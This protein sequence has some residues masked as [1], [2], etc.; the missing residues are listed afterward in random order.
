M[1][2]YNSSHHGRQCRPHWLR[3]N[4][5]CFCKIPILP[6]SV[7]IWLVSPANRFSLTL[8]ISVCVQ[9]PPGHPS[10]G[11]CRTGEHKSSQ[12]R[13]FWWMLSLRPWEWCVSIFYDKLNKC[14]ILQKLRGPHTKI[15][16]VF[17]PHTPHFEKAS[18][19]VIGKLLIFVAAL[20]G[21]VLRKAYL[22]LEGSLR[23]KKTL[24]NELGGSLWQ[25]QF[26]GLFLRR[27]E[28]AGILRIKKDSRVY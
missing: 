27:K 19:G 21:G 18:C 9:W 16:L 4:M 23:E 8:V 24:R 25:A 1:S 15:H 6:L 28:G 7:I 26:S 20:E 13:L 10:S 14:P 5:F 3:I 12:L 22:Y 17:Q 11:Q 2:I